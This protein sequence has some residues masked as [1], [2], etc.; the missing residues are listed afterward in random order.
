MQIT[1]QHVKLAKRMYV[2]WDDCEYG[3]PAIDPKRPYGNSDVEGDIAD[4]LGWKVGE[5]G[6][7]EKQS[8]EASRLHLEMKDVIE[9]ALKNLDKLTK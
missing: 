9:F 6:L 3:A 4:I 8:E 5:D 2:G 1:K 7:S